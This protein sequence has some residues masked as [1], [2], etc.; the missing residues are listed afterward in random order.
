MAYVCRKKKAGSSD[1]GL[2]MRNF[3]TTD[4]EKEIVTVPDCK[5]DVKDDDGIADVPP[6][7]SHS[8]AYGLISKLMIGGGTR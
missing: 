8:E 7:P 4:E 2:E 1:A 5:N 3:R 6:V